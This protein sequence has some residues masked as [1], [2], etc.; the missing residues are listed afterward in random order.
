MYRRQRA[1]R[2]RGKVR[3]R[4]QDLDRDGGGIVTPGLKYGGVDESLRE[5]RG[6]LRVSGGAQ[7]LFDL[8]IPE[9]IHQTV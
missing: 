3:G 1:G 8:P 7:D 4:G 2:S 9:P 6:G 5:A